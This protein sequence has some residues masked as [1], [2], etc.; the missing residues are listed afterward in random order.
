[1]LM[2]DY[3]ILNFREM[4]LNDS[5]CFSLQE[6]LNMEQRFR[7]AFINSIT[8]FKSLALIGTKNLDNQ[9]NLAIFNS[10]VHLGANP[11]LIG[12]IWRPEYVE[13]HNL[14]NIEQT[15]YYTLNHV[16]E[17]I[18]K[19]AHQTSARYPAEVSEFQATG[20]TEQYLDE[21][22]APFVK[23]SY[24]KIGLKFKQ[25]VDISLNQT[26][27]IIGE[28]QSVYFPDNCLFTDGFLDLEKAQ[29]I[30]CG[31]LDSYHTT[32]RLS[33]LAYAKPNQMPN[34]IN[35]NYINT[36]ELWKK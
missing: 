15:K 16:N 11:P 34:T 20:L 12:F 27:L 19:A 6:I 10:L 9:S 23:E 24:V 36:K 35:P 29:S 28:I 31:G 5:K 18:Y 14:T 21:F 8:G 4:N 7:A 1:M 26:S 32:N 33:R 25:R 13:R 22:Y 3:Q 2:E 17:K 30:A